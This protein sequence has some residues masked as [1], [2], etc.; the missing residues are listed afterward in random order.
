MNIKLGR[1]KY[2]IKSDSRQ[3]MLLK[4]TGKKDKDNNIIYDYLGY[5]AHIENLIPALLQTA[6]YLSR[7]TDFDTY[8]KDITK[9]KKDVE[10]I[11]VNMAKL[12][13]NEKEFKRLLNES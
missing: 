4:D 5:Y 6:S 10:K 8:I 11:A 1:G 3:Y 12:I 7:A 13:G 2:V 9:I